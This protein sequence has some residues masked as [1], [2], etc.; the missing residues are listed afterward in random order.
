MRTFKITRPEQY[1]ITLIFILLFTT[2]YLSL[3]YTST[4]AIALQLVIISKSMLFTKQA[5]QSAK[6]I[7]TALFISPEPALFL[8]LPLY[9]LRILLTAQSRNPRKTNFDTTSKLFISLLTLSFFLFLYNL[10]SE[11]LL[12]NYIFWLCTFGSALAIY[13][14]GREISSRVPLKDII[15]FVSYCFF[16]QISL[17]LVQSI[18]NNSITPGDWAKGTLLDAHRLGIFIII[19]I[20]YL[21]LEF[22]RRPNIKHF[23]LA[24]LA[25]V[26]FYVCDAK[27][28]LLCSL[29]ALPIYLI[30][31]SPIVG[32]TGRYFLFPRP[33]ITAV[34]LL[35]AY[36]FIFF[37]ADPLKNFGNIDT[38][39]VDD[40]VNSKYV[41]YNRVWFDIFHDSYLNWL[42]GTGPGTLGSRAGNILSSDVLYKTSSTLDSWSASS[43]W[44]RNYMRGLWTEELASSIGNYSAILSYPFSGLLSI[45]AELGLIG[46]II[47]YTSIFSVSFSLAKSVNYKSPSPI[48]TLR[49]TLSISMLI[50]ALLLFFDNY[51][52][53]PS[54]AYLLYFL[55]GISYYNT[56]NPNNVT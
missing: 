22:F 29:I 37:I 54:V 27:S 18:A 14:Y 8:I 4:P 15:R 36:G 41:F 1:D 44:T 21:S 39:I 47:Y 3:G 45:K 7:I 51:Q 13:F 6:E 25:L 24:T 49:L 52:E 42:A 16:V 50:Y 11:G 43:L 55:C 46:L 2:L 53:Q 38:Y 32:R 35:S 28:I 20:V 34:F 33:F 26:A 9:L 19:S 40:L 12:L 10:I 30:A 56:K 48:D 31:I 17:V 23:S 5:N